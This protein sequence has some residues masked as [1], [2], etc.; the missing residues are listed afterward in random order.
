MVYKLDT[1]DIHTNSYGYVSC[2]DQNNDELFE[3]R[4]Q[5]ECPFQVSL[6]GIP[7]PCDVCEF[8]LV[9][10]L[11]QECAT[12]INYHC[13]STFQS[14]LKL[15]EKACLEHMDY[16]LGGQ[17]YYYSPDVEVAN[18]L[19]V[20]ITQGRNGKGVIYLFSSGNEFTMGEDSMQKGA[21]TNTRFTLTIGALDQTGKQ[22][23]YSAQGM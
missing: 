6:E 18:A 7:S 11:P 10:P 20:G 3:R 9:D 19:A 4:L 17:C 21:F 8:P 13:Y 2:S 23:P 16:V 5:E 12:I 22:A 14:D 1:F 15:E